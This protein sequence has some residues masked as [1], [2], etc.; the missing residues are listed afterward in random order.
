[1]H[2]SGIHCTVVSCTV[3]HCTVVHSVVISAKLPQDLGFRLGFDDTVK[4]CVST[5]VEREVNVD[6]FHTIPFATED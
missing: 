3:V 4:N 1:M 2:C 5:E 6:K